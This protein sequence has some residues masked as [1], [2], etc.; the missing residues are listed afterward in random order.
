[1]LVFFSM[2]H[3][4]P[5]RVFRLR[6]VSSKELARKKDPTES[7]HS[8]KPDARLGL[9]ALVLPGPCCRRPGFDGNGRMCVVRG[10]SGHQKEVVDS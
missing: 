4:N 9:S 3:Q 1:M 8:K 5:L 6:Q 2:W 7:Q 10:I